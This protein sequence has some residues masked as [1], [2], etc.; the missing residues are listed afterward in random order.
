MSAAQLNA[1]ASVSGTFVYAPAAG[2]VLT[3][4]IQLLSVTF[5]PDDAANVA[6]CQASATLVVHELPNVGFAM[7]QNFQ[8][9][10]YDSFQTPRTNPA[11]FVAR[12]RWIEEAGE[13]AEGNLVLVETRETSLPMPQKPVPEQAQIARERLGADLNVNPAEEPETRTYKG[14]TYMKGPDGQWHRLPN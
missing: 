1:V 4:G 8:A 3:P 14:V 2:T 11:S 12:R 13:D 5:Y 6:M 9:D 7:P 10:V